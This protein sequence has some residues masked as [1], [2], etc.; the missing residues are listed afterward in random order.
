MGN[1]NY[2]NGAARE[3]RIKKYLEADGM[4]VFRQAG[5]HSHYD[6]LAFNPRTHLINFIQVKPKSLSKRKKEAL[7]LKESWMPGQWIIRT[8][9]VSLGKE[10][11]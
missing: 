11:A 3:R 6:L 9:C 8:H 7:A 4:I 10:I 1:R 5:S 2:V